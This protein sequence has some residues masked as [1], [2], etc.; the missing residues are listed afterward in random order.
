MSEYQKNLIVKNMKKKNDEITSEFKVGEIVKHKRRKIHYKIN[1]IFLG[2]VKVTNIKTGYS[3][4]WLD[5][6][7][8][9][10]LINCP[11][12]LKS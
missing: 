2:E 3:S 7:E 8:F 10:K 9:T 5:H 1:N 6:S 11:E 4:Q 12:Y